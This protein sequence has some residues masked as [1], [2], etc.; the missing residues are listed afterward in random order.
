M[1]DSRE[2]RRIRRAIAKYGAEECKVAAALSLTGYGASG[3]AHEGPVT[4]RTT[5]AADAAIGAG[6]AL[7]ALPRLRCGAHHVWTDATTPRTDRPVVFYCYL[8]PGPNGRPIRRT[9]VGV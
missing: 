2:S 7:L 5:R 1:F 9:M 8:V 4:I 6:M 3:I